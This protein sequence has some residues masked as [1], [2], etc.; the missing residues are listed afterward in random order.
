MSRGQWT[1]DLLRAVMN[2]ANGS[3]AEKAAALLTGKMTDE[4]FQAY[5]GGFLMACYKGDFLEAWVRAD[6]DNREALLEVLITYGLGDALIRTDW[7]PQ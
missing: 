7:K 2:S 3:C 5:A 1:N 4:Q 6:E